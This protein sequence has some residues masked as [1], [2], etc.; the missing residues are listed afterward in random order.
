[1]FQ[2]TFLYAATA[3]SEIV[4]V[5]M[6]LRWTTH[7]APTPLTLVAA[8]VAL[9]LFL[10]L[11]RFHPARERAYTVYAGL[12][13]AVVMLFFFI[14]DHVEPTKAPALIWKSGTAH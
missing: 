6:A 3:I 11:L 1:M 8:T 9:A 14:V 12:G 5:V 10:F 4:A 13:L 2:R 7:I